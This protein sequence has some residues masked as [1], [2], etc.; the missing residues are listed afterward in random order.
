M[1]IVERRLVWG[2]IGKLYD[3]FKFVFF[4]GGKYFYFLEI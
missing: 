1:V 4:W 2:G 3:V